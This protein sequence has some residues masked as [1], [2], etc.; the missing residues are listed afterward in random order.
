LRLRR[1]WSTG[2]RAAI[3]GF[4]RSYMSFFENPAPLGHQFQGQ[5]K[6]VGYRKG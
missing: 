2:L 1:L 5:D 4:G 3:R 6:A